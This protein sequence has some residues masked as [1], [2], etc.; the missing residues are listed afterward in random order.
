MLVSIGKSQ[1]RHF[2]TQWPRNWL[3]SISSFGRI[4]I[5][6]CILW[7]IWRPPNQCT[8]GSE[9]CVERSNFCVPICWPWW[10]RLHLL[11]VILLINGMLRWWQNKDSRLR[12]QYRLP[13]RRD[14]EHRWSNWSSC[15]ATTNRHYVRLTLMTTIIMIM[16]KRTL[17]STILRNTMMIIIM[18]FI[19][20]STM[21]LRIIIIHMSLYPTTTLNSTTDFPS[22]YKYVVVFDRH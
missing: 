22:T 9:I 2:C 4:M 20:Y 13:Q 19:F 11:L 6:Y 17:Q 10:Q 7:H 3:T 8:D 14:V 15:G 16:V 21:S 18:K 1:C 5:Y 12:H